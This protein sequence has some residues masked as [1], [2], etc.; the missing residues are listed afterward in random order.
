MDLNVIVCDDIT[1][2]VLAS[3]AGWVAVDKPCGLSIHNEPGNDLCSIVAEG[4]KEN[5]FSVNPVNRIDRDTSGVILLGLD[6]PTTSFLGRQFQERGVVKKYIA[7][8]HGQPGVTKET[9]LWEMRLADKPGGRKN[10]VGQGKKKECLTKYEVLATSIH[11]SLI[12]C[13][14]LTGRKH[15][16][17]RHARLNKTPITGDKRYG[18]PKSLGYLSVNCDYHRL[19]LHSCELKIITPE[20]KAL[21]IKSPTPPEFLR[22]IR[23]D[24]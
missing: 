22:M 6:K 12:E 18:S 23:D 13:E 14:L 1:I 9:G 20:K 7:L 3:G 17:R 19:G 15:Q 11:Y 5:A 8:V 4:L 24:Q 21:T 16:I 10:P 2:P